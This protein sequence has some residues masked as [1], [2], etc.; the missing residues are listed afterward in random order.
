MPVEF[1]SDDEAA[2]YARY[3]GTPSQ[4]ELAKVCFLD[5]EDLKL[6][7]R[8]RGPHMKLGF[9]LQLVTVRYLGV[10]LENPIDVP[11]AVLDFV[12]DQLGIADPSCVKAYTERRNTRFEHA[13]E[14]T[15][16]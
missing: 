8:R 11:S 9:A 4:A 10:F 12:A 14:I 7:A 15:R 3:T 6:I 16:V 2:A 1:L 5:D 13:W